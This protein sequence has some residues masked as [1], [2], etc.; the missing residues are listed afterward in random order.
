MIGTQV[1]FYTAGTFQFRSA[2]S[3]I[4][5]FIDEKQLYHQAGDLVKFLDKWE[6]KSQV[7]FECVKAMSHDMAAANFWSERDAQFVDAW[8][9]D[10]LALGYS[11]P[12]LRPISSQQCVNNPTNVIFYPQEQLAAYGEVP[13]YYLP[14][15]VRSKFDALGNIVKASCPKITNPSTEVSLNGSSL[16]NNILLIIHLDGVPVPDLVARLEVFYRPRFG[17]ILYCGKWR[18]TV[19]PIFHMWR[20]SYAE[21]AGTSGD[22]QMECLYK[23]ADMHYIVDGYMVIHQR[24]L[25]NMNSMKKNKGSLWVTEN[26]ATTSETSQCLDASCANVEINVET[27]NKIVTGGTNINTL[28]TCKFNKPGVRFNYLKDRVFFVPSV[29][30]RYLRLASKA[31]LEGVSMSAWLQCVSNNPITLKKSQDLKTA[32]VYTDFVQ[33]FDFTDMNNLCPVLG[34]NP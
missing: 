29:F 17:Q 32:N 25:F 9:Q 18:D 30:D 12:P 2:H 26:W 22:P 5:D 1:G 14:P 20:A 15:F 31:S 19:K 33:K 6:C 28:S 24:T 13:T 4:K 23:A 16:I 10:L 3:Y 27:A 34:F 11:P 7:F 21:I 8:L